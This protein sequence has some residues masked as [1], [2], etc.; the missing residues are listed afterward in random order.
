SAL[1]ATVAT[2]SFSFAAV[3][4]SARDAH[5]QQPTATAMQPGATAPPPSTTAPYGAPMSAGGLAPPPP[6]T[7]QPPGA[8]GAPPPHGAPPVA[9]PS[10]YEDD[11]DSSKD[12][13]SGRGLSWFWIDFHGGFEHVGLKTFNV[14]EEAFTA[15][16][17]DTTASGGVIE[18]GIGAQI[19][20]LTLGVRGR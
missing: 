19:V 12:D 6:L 3:T 4:F 7:A 11:L 8:N 17:V 10:T 15:G 9:P 5:A 14:D 2:L 16:F 20:F 13:D 18:A 1:A